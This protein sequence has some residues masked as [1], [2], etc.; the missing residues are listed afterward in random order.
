MAVDPL[1]PILWEPHMAALD[2]RVG[3]VLQK[4]RE[5]LLAFAA[6]SAMSNENTPAVPH[7]DSDTKDEENGNKYSNATY[8]AEEIA[9]ATKRFSWQGGHIDTS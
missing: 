5:C 3:F 1:T 2:R 9:L 6:S 4:V 8:R 7:E